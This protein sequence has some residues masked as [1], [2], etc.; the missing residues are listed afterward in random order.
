MQWWPDQ[1][2]TT[3]KDYGTPKDFFDFE[4]NN[5]E[6]LLLLGTKMADRIANNGMRRP[7]FTHHRALNRNFVAA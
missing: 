1:R 4:K 2:R 3:V 6:M 5:F 7:H